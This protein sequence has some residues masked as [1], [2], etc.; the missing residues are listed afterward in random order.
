MN[1]MSDLVLLT[2]RGCVH[3][4]DMRGHLDAALRS[5]HRPAAYRIVDVDVLPPSDLR[6]GYGTPTILIGGTDLFGLP[7]PAV[8]GPAAT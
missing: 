8:A 1:A 4:D 2:R 3:T 5:L 6:R 7:E